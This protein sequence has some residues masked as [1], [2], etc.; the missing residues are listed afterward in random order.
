[1]LFL[2]LEKVNLRENKVLQTSAQPN[3]KTAI[4]L[5]IG[6]SASL[7]ELSVNNL[8]YR[9]FCTWRTKWS[10]HK[11]NCTTNVHRHKIQPHQLYCLFTPQVCQ[12]IVGM[13]LLLSPFVCKW[14]LGNNSIQ[15][16]MLNQN[17]KPW[18]P[19]AQKTCWVAAQVEPF[20]LPPRGA[21]NKSESSLAGISLTQ[22]QC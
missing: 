16:K 11:A 21:E 10:L 3:S 9:V 19:Q 17:L 8:F 20:T 2:R 13:L 4:I 15:A 14:R 18:Q 12:E 6:I 22:Y 1:M 5:T 7:W